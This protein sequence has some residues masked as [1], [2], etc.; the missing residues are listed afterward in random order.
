M[1]RTRED[2]PTPPATQ[3][4]TR[5]SSEPSEPPAPPEEGD[6]RRIDRRSFLRGIGALGAAA[7]VTGLDRFALGPRELR[8]QPVALQQATTYAIHPAL[9]VARVGNAPVDPADPSSWYLAAE[10]PYEVPNAG[11]PYKVGGRIK[12]QGR[13]FRIYEFEDGTATR[14]ITLAEDDIEDITWTVHLANRKAAFD[15]ARAPGSVSCP[16]VVPATYLPAEARNADVPAADRDRLAI[17]PGPR[18][19]SGAGARI[20]LVGE[21]ALPGATGGPTRVTL[22]QLHT[23]ADTGRLV[24]FA[25]DGLSQGVLAGELSE[26]APISPS[27][28]D[29]VNN[30][31]WHDDTADGWVRA[32]ITFRDGTRVAL[33]QPGQAAWVICA[34]P[35]FAPGLNQ[36]TSLHD[37]AANAF[38]R[39]GSDVPRPSFARDIW[40]ILRSASLLSWVSARASLGHSAG[41]GGY[42]LSED[43]LRLMASNDPGDADARR[44]RQR[45]FSRI[46][47]PLSYDITNE[48]SQDM[49]RLPM[50]VIESPGGDEQGIPWDI[51]AV[52]PLQYARLRKWA[53][54][55]FE[56]DGVPT[57]VPL[58]RLS[59]ADQPAALDR[60]ALEA[61]CGT[62][63]FPGIES[64]KITRERSLYADAPLRMSAPVRPGDLTICNAVPWQAD[65]L[66]CTDA[67][68]PVQRPTEVTRNGV[69]AQS[70]APLDWGEHAEVTEYGEMVRHWWQ[71]GFVVST[72]GGATYREVERELEGGA[73][74]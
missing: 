24:V 25:G 43:L 72:D 48:S 2:R 39:P 36:F 50:Q 46:R 41:R 73:E 52:T 37:V 32:E 5:A 28:D 51:G 35:R 44:M 55:D 49:P 33:D 66:D 8:G 6:P 64:W 13:R 63:F 16:A 30:D 69:P 47:D 45:V 70:W 9:G 15:P 11:R 21:I 26:Y 65:Y 58:D 38:H 29:W 14:E 22:G 19:V 20:D 62:P 61:T 17:D 4:A 74:P 1:A 34:C 18:S 31:G 23:E 53:D 27:A 3:D 12:K 54:G 59:V 60:A 7:G 10:S 67:W 40:P 42:Y 57:F 56:A 71:L 68:W